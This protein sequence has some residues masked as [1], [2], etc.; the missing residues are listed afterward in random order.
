MKIPKKI[1][2]IIA[3]RAKL[4]A[5]LMNADS[6][7]VDWLETKDLIDKIE[8]YDILTGAEMY[9]NPYDSADRIRK[10]ILDN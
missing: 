10:V 7:L 5:D 9:V 2:K 4:A 1:E 8:E 3:R 6:Q